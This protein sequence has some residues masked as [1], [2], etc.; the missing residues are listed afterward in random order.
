MTDVAKAK[1]F[2]K[3]VAATLEEVF[4]W[5]RSRVNSEIARVQGPLTSTGIER[6][7]IY[8]SQPLHVAADM[9]GGLEPIGEAELQHYAAVLTK[10]KGKKQLALSP[11]VEP[12]SLTPQARARRSAVVL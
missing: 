8:H 2:W 1:L 6:N 7:L 10:F 11:P 4:Q 3:I 5:P 12:I 9:A